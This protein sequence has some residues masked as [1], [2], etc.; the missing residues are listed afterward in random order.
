MEKN[1]SI[2]RV[3]LSH[4]TIPLED[5][6]IL[7]VPLARHCALE[8]L[9][10]S[11]CRV[12]SAFG[13]AFKRI[14]AGQTERRCEIVW[15]RGLHGG[16]PEGYEHRVGLAELV[17]EQNRI[18]DQFVDDIV[19]ALGHDEFLLVLDLRYNLVGCKGAKQL[20]DLLQRNNHTLINVDIRDNPGTSTGCGDEMA[21]RLVKNIQR[22]K[23]DKS[24][25]RL[26]LERGWINKDVLRV[27]PGGL[28]KRSSSVA[29]SP[30]T[31]ATAR[32]SP[33][34]QGKSCRRGKER[35]SP[36]KVTSLRG[37]LAYR[38]R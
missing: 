24:Y 4:T 31:L 8:T 19:Q 22:H 34:A 10:M 23:Q 28:H 30:Q 25:F 7:S 20:A 21:Y 18:S 36:E 38:R 6:A 33:T 26:I 37:K 32:D 12:D 17:L 29:V 3:S 27:S 2:V 35:M 14:I 13:L 11:D 15:K 9:E 1:H 5:F 16:R